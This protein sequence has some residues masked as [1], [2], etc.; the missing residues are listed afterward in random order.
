[1]TEKVPRMNIL[2]ANY[3]YFIS[4]GPERYLFNAKK[5]FEVNGHM[6]I[7]FSV[8]HPKNRETDFDKFFLSSLSEDKDASTLRQFKKTPKTLLKLFDR[9]F[10]SLEA[11]A[12]V[13]KLLEHQDIDVAYVLHFLRWISP[14]IF[15]EFSRRGIPTVVRI[16]D[17]EYMCPGAH[18]LREGEICELCIGKKLWPSVKYKCIQDSYPLSL[19]HFLAMTFHKKRGFLDKIDAFICP[20]QFTLGKMIDAGYE[21]RKLFHVPTFVDFQRIT[22]KFDSG[23]YILYFGRL[24]VEKGID[25][26][27]DAID[28][29]KRR[30]HGHVMPLY[31]I[32]TGMDETDQLEQRVKSENLKEVKILTDLSPKEF[33]S[34]VQHSAFTIVPSLF[35]ENLPNVILESYAYG[36]PVVG[37]R[38]GS[39]LEVIQDGKTGLLFEPGDTQDLADKIGWLVNH[40]DE[41]VKMGRNARKLAESEYN[42][43]LHYD[44]LMNVFKRFL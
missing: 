21:K 30:N 39:F 22:P 33:Y 37:S 36:K 20:S 25:L 14:S 8:K 9:T 40:P 24:S 23:E 4:G 34:Y 44:R 41:C 42:R 17:F 7:P 38:R 13:N 27:I 2:L 28:V 32:Q 19:V 11:R 18:L 10:Y 26:L 43:D 35:Y 12:K 15:S 6:V 5:M 3:R 1:M 16:S 31:I 29:Y